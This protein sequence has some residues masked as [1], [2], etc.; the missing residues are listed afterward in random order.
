MALVLAFNWAEGRDHGVPAASAG[1]LEDA[2][3]LIR[4]GAFDRAADL[5]QRVIASEPSNRQARE[6]LAFALEST[7]DLEGERRVRASLAR[8][9]PVDA[10]LQVDYARVLERSGDES[11]ALQ[12]YRRARELEGGRAA[13][14]LDLAIDRMRGRTSP[15]F[16]APLHVMSDPEATSSHVRAGVALPLQPRLHVAVLGSRMTARGRASPAVT[17]ADVASLSGV[18]RPNRGG[19][20]AGRVHVHVLSPTSDQ[21]RDL[22][23]GGSLAGRTPLGG[24]F[25]AEWGA[26][27]DSPWDEAAVAI[28]HG[29]RASGAEGRLYAHGFARRLLLQA[30]VRERRLS[31]LEPATGDRP[32]ARQSLALAGADVILW[33][34]PGATLRGEMLDERLTAGTSLASAITLSYRHYDVASRPTP[35][36]ASRVG[37]APRARV[38]EAS[39]SASMAAWS[40]RVGL[41]VQA[42]L[43]RDAIRSARSWRVGGAL[44]CAVSPRTRVAVG[45]EEAEEFAAGLLGIRRSGWVSLHA[46]L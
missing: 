36:F 31:I 15:E 18:L 20:A 24:P 33:Q 37:L 23:F 42:G 9:F 7:G 14:D 27:L 11:G 17:S 3:A 5:L 25:E 19:H 41:E 4:T 1:T 43:A 29:G 34:L 32:E 21:H 39:A 40:G 30:G 8:D 45:F 10:R 35:G 16:G 22:A 44:H 6:M 38:D 13:P 46:D 26:E 28:L 2:S 12:R